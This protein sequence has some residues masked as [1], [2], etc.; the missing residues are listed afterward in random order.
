[1]GAWRLAIHVF[2]IFKPSKWILYAISE[3]VY[4]NLISGMA[5]KRVK[6][7]GDLRANR[8]AVSELKSWINGAFTYSHSVRAN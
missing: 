6:N 7:E 1:L 4:R 5:A 2:D 8:L 3:T